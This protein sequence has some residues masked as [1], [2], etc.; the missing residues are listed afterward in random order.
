MNCPKCGAKSPR[1]FD[2]KS[3]CESIHR[4]RKCTE[5]G[6]TFYTVEYEAPNGFAF[7]EVANAYYQERRRKLDKRTAK[8]IQGSKA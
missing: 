3:D 1:T 2:S 6:H 8:S 7:H 4:R 5:C